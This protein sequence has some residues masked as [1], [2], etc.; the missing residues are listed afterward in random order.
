VTFGFCL[1]AVTT[2]SGTVAG[3]VAAASLIACLISCALIFRTAPSPIAIANADTA[4]SSRNVRSRNL[5]F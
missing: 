5:S 4:A 1:G 3:D 2:I